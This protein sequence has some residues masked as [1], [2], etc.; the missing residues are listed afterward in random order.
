MR[1][2]RRL[3]LGRDRRALGELVEPPGDAL[4]QLHAEHVAEPD[5]PRQ[6]G[7]LD[8]PERAVDPLVEIR[9]TV[10]E[11]LPSPVLA[12]AERVVGVAERIVE[13]V[14]A[15][16]GKRTRG[17]IG[18]KQRRLGVAL[19][20]VLHDHRR[21][22]QDEGVLLDH[23]H[24]AERVLLVQPRGPV[25]EVDLDGLVLDPLLGED[26]AHAGAVRAAGGVVERQHGGFSLP[27]APRPAA[28][29][30]PPPAGARRPRRA[31]RATARRRSGSAPVSRCAT[32][33]FAP[34]ATTSPGGKG[35]EVLRERTRTRR[36]SRRDP[37]GCSGRRRASSIPSV[38][39]MLSIA[40]E[41]SRPSRRSAFGSS[42]QSCVVDAGPAVHRLLHR[43]RRRA[44]DPRQVLRDRPLDGVVVV[45]LDVG[46]AATTAGRRRRAGPRRP[47][48][49]RPSSTSSARS[50]AAARPRPPPR[51]RR[52]RRA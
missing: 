3:E 27:R 11:P 24:L 40:S 23:R 34:S 35:P 14:D 21:L 29:A 39:T 5:Q 33:G 37:R 9:K 30:A 18:G 10:V 48:A 4:G 38:S 13:A 46:G 16:P 36:R 42:L 41:S 44:P 43:R 32:V 31:V 47:R 45:G 19:L 26:D 15:Q 6:V 1:T 2:R 22:G 12:P 8:E 50:R 17:G 25:A 28:R 51:S 20:E 49:A 7:D 52:A